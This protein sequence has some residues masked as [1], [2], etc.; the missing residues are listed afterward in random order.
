[1]I[2]EKNYLKQIQPTIK[3]KIKCYFV[4]KIICFKTDYTKINFFDYVLGFLYGFIKNFLIYIL[5]ISILVI[6]SISYV[7]KIDLLSFLE[8]DLKSLSNLAITLYGFQFALLSLV[9]SLKS[10][11]IFNKSEFNMISDIDAYGYNIKSLLHRS[12]I[13]LIIII[14][15][16]CINE[17][18]KI[19]IIFSL[20]ISL[21]LLARINKLVFASTAEIEYSYNNRWVRS[22]YFFRKRG[23]VKSFLKKDELIE[24]NRIDKML[25]KAYDLR[26]RNLIVYLEKINRSVF[27]YE[28]NELNYDINLY[29]K[30]LKLYFKSIGNDSQI[31]EMLCIFGYLVKMF[32]TLIDRNMHKEIANYLLKTLELFNFFLKR[33]IISKRFSINVKNKYCLYLVLKYNNELFNLY[34]RNEILLFCLE[35]QINKLNELITNKNII[36]NKENIFDS[37]IKTI[38]KYIKENN[39]IILNYK[40][41]NE[42]FINDI[43]ESINK[44]NKEICDYLIDALK[45]VQI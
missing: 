2:K 9:A 29:E 26:M 45:K 40:N 18:N 12:F 3:D 44:Q 25:E 8:S 31:V 19:L 42:K 4:M 21:N 39:D 7:M 22:N 11:N 30:Y 1:M 13:N 10:K 17:Y 23:N 37:D 16:M 5:M 41:N 24:K 20:F 36:T 27:Y 34:L 43:I 14:F 38:S 28:K 35:T 32:T 33:K 6:Y 15:G